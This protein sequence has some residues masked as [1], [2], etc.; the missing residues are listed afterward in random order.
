MSAQN[1][2]IKMKIAV[3]GGKGGTGKSMVATSIAIT[4]SKTKRVLL[5]DADVECPND[6]LIINTKQKYHSTVHQAIPKW[7]LKKC[8]QCG[9]CAEA[10]KKDAII[11]VKN[12]F[13]AFIRSACIGCGACIN[14]CP[15]KAITKA[16]TC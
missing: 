7:N 2:A 10:C 13:P 15:N 1:I 9:L 8:T 12:K 3:S 11:F 6:H 14:S 4:L 5:A 16:G